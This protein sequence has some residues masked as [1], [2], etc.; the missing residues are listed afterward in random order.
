MFRSGRDA[1]PDNRVWCLALPGVR[2]WLGDPANVREW[3]GF[4]PGCPEMVG[5]PAMTSRSGREA[6]PGVWEW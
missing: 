2:E 5:R 3:S 1:L 6:L 4:R